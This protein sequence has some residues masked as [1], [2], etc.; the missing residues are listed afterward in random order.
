MAPPWP[1]FLSLPSSEYYIH[2]ISKRDDMKYNEDKG[3]PS[4]TPS[5]NY[6][7]VDD[8]TY[9]RLTLLLIA[10]ILIIASYVISKFYMKKNG[11]PRIR[12]YETLSVKQLAPDLILNSDDSDDEDDDYLFGSNEDVHRQLISTVTST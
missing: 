8:K 9:L 5:T 6:N 11:P 4:T 3:I 2:K 7:V 1:K 10:I 12:R